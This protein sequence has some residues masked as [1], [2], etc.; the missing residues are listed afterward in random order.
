MWDSEKGN[1]KEV[2]DFIS[3]KVPHNKKEEALGAIHANGYV[4]DEKLDKA[5]EDLVP[6]DGSDW[7]KEK[8][9]HYHNEL[10]RLRK[11][12]AAVSQSIGTDMKYCLA[13]YIGAY[14]KS[15]HYRLLKTVCDEERDNKTA[16]MKHDYDACAVCGDGGSLLICD[17]CEGEYHIGCLRPALRTVP[18]GHWEC[19]ECVNRKLLL[20]K[21]TVM[22]ESGLFENPHKTQGKR[23]ADEMD[24][25]AED[26]ERKVEDKGTEDEQGEGGEREVKAL[27]LVPPNLQAKPEVLDIIRE[28]A[29]G[30]TEALTSE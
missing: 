6:T 13:Y 22:T 27:S 3:E 25:D 18:E 28:L 10:F 7:P 17:G 12:V 1:R 11:D 15:D 4:I 8:K 9:D 2:Q 30:V 16:S 26:D 5:I 29:K 19:D 23:K 21:I 14:K 24:V 20:S